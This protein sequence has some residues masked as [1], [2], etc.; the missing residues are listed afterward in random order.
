MKYLKFGKH[1]LAA[2]GIIVVALCLRLLVISQG[3]PM[4]NSDEGTIGIMARHIAYRGEWPTFYYG[5]YYMGVLQAYLG[6]ALFHIFGPS[7][8][9]LRLGLVLLTVGFLI[10]MYLLTSVLYSRPF[11]LF[12]VLL[13]TFGSYYLLDYQLHAIGG[14]PETFFFG[15]LLFLLAASL[16]IT[17]SAFVTWHLHGW[18]L[19][20]YGIWGSAAGLGVWSDSLTLPLIAA[21]GLLL[22]FFCWR[23]LLGIASALC[24]LLGFGLGALPLIR[25]NLTAAPGE[26]SFSVLWGLQHGGQSQLHYT[27]PFLLLK[28]LKSTV[29]ISVP[30][31]TGNPWCPVSEVPALLDPNHASSFTCSLIHATWGGSY[32]LLFVCAMILALWMMWRA[33]RRTRNQPEDTERRRELVRYCARV[34]LLLSSLLT[35]YL[36]ATSTAP[37][38]WPGVEARYLIGLWVAWPAVLWPLWSLA[39]PAFSRLKLAGR[40]SKLASSAILACLVC[41]YII[42]SVMV[43]ADIPRVQN[44]NQTYSSLINYLVRIHATHIYTDYWTCNKI[45]FFS[46]EHI[47]CGVINGRLQPSHNRVPDYYQTVHTDPTSAYVFSVQGQMRSVLNL[48]EKHPSQYRRYVFDGYVVYQPVGQT[49]ATSPQL[50]KNS[51]H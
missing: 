10:T 28:E 44:D 31:V 20:G 25:Y 43:V 23:E 37:L 38:S 21:S 15:A 18:R 46:Q 49:G 8:F 17:S 11:A 12:I 34:L 16:A 48:V 24:I 13:L 6:A 1:E 2:L 41:V 5:Q 7:V 22:L 45:A 39:R 4:L 42:G 40:L 35:L 26:D 14:Y 3:W 29:F 50:A 47:I 36:F 30:M 51:R 32:M 33:W 9:S 19:L 27:L